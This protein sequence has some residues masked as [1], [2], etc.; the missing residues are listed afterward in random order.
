MTRIPVRDW[1]RSL[2]EAE[3][4]QVETRGNLIGRTLPLGEVGP[5]Y[6]EYLRLTEPS[7]EDMEWARGQVE[8]HCD[9]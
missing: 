4:A 3:I 9:R 2:S 6:L 7:G 5:A 1:P 8:Q